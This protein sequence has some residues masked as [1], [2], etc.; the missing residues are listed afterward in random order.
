MYKLSKYVGIKHCGLLRI[1][2]MC[3]DF[4]SLKLV[5]K[6]WIH[7]FCSRNSII[8]NQRDLLGTNDA[9]RKPCKN[10]LFFLLKHLEFS[11]IC[12]LKISKLEWRQQGREAGWEAVFPSYLSR[13]RKSQHETWPA[14][15]L[16][17]AH[18]S[19]PALENFKYIH[20]TLAQQT[21]WRATPLSKII[22]QR[23]VLFIIQQECARHFAHINSLLTGTLFGRF[24]YHVYI[25]MT[26]HRKINL[27]RSNSK[28]TAEP[29]IKPG[30]LAP[31]SMLLISTGLIYLSSI[32]GNII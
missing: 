2:P 30:S 8:R 31:E 1:W 14:H 13:Q 3:L 4:C 29:G 15:N 9:T 10:E 27:P 6:N 26:E 25:E 32:N 18:S 5:Y 11:G 19:K 16:Q 22:P 17:P 24:Y 28:Y 7:S 23:Y 21:L 12:S 20:T